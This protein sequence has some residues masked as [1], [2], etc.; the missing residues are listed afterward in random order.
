M[1]M[2]R[3]RTKRRQ[4]LL[5]CRHFTID[6]HLEVLEY[7]REKTFFQFEFGQVA[8]IQF[9]EIDNRFHDC[10]CTNFISKFLLDKTFELMQHGIHSFF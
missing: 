2:N 1:G 5:S 9:K 10:V 6:S 4:G 7:S 3:R 8:L